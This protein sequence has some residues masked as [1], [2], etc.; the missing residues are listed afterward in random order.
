[1]RRRLAAITVIGMSCQPAISAT[2]R[3]QAAHLRIEFVA[4]ADSLRRATRLYDS[5]WASDG[6]RM[7]HALETAAG[8]KFADIGDTTVRAIVCEGVSSSGYRTSPMHLR[9]SYPVA[10]KKA[11]LMHELGHRLE[12]D[13]FR[14]SEDDHPYLFL[15]LY[16][17]W[18]AAYGEDFARDQVA[19]EKR[20]GGVYPA[21]WDAALAR[22]PAERRARW[23]SVRA[24]RMDPLCPNGVNRRPKCGPCRC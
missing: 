11:T 9:A 17:A 10:T 18:V 15:W 1:M 13:L 22:S 6:A 16:P 8:L 5:L 4:G 24:S 7:T 2:P 23:D 20:R 19:V 21:A 12:S 3:T 14:A